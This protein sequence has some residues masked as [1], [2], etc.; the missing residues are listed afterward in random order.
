MVVRPSRT[1]SSAG[2]HDL[3]GVDEP[4]V[5]Q[6]RLDHDLGAVAEG[7]GDDLVFDQRHHL[8]RTLLAMGERRG[9][10]NRVIR[11]RHHGEPFVGD[12]DVTCQRLETVEPAQVIGHE[13]QEIGLRLAERALAFRHFPSDGGGLGVG[14][15]ILAHVALAVHQPVTGDAS[16]LRHPV[17]VEIMRAGD[18]HR[19]RAEIG[20]G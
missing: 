6:H 9:A 2:T 4:L 17:V 14:Q 12:L 15:A 10:E 19:A 1:A 18:L 8:V 20:S 13:I 5:G 16:A 3:G 7:L 11:P